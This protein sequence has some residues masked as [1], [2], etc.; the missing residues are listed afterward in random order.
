LKIDE[1]KYIVLKSASE[2]MKKEG[3]ASLKMGLVTYFK[4][5]KVENIY[6]LYGRVRDES[7][8][9]ELN[10]HLKIDFKKKRLEG[11]ECTC[12]EHK[13][14][15]S[16][17]YTFMCAHLTATA[18]KFFSLLS[19][20]E[21]KTA[22]EIEKNTD[23]KAEAAASTGIGRLIRKTEKASV[24][25]EGQEASGSE[26]LILK[27]DEI[28]AF[29]EKIKN[30]K[31]KFKFDYIEFIAQILHEDLPLT[32]NLKEAKE[33]I[34]VTTQKQLPVPL[35]SNNDVFY[36]KSQLYLPSKA[37]IEKYSAIY[38]KLKTKGETYYKKDI[39][40]YNSLLSFLSSISK[41]INIAE[42]LR[43]FMSALSKP[44]FLMY[45]DKG[46]IYCQVFLN[47]GNRKVNILEQDKSTDTLHRDY[48][49]EEKLLMEVERHGL[50][51]L[52]NRFLFT[53]N[54]EE[55]V[56]IL[57]R[58]GQGI[59]SI[60]RV[61]FGKG[62]K[63]IKIYNRDSIEADLYEKEGS[64]DFVYSIGNL[65]P[66]ELKSAFEAYRAKSK[67]YKTRDNGFIDF[68]DDVVRGLFNMFEV[69]NFD[70]E[71][72]DGTVKVEKSKALYVY[73]NLKNMG[74]SFVKG[75][76]AME[77]L[78]KKLTDVNSS[79]IALPQK[80]K[81]TLR[82]YQIK[83]FKWLKTL[84]KLGFGGILAD[85]MGLGKTIQT[86]AFILS[87]ENKRTLIVCPTSLIYNWREEFERFAPSLKVGIL[88]G[89]ERI[90]I[91]KNLD[92][93]DV[94]LTTYSTLRMDIEKYD[95]IL[96]H[97]C[98]IDE[99]Q[100]IKNVS[101]QNTKVIKEI[102]AEVKFALTGTPLENN[103]TELWSIF[104]FV[105]PGY[106][107]SKERFEEKFLAN[108]GENFDNLKLLIKPF[109]LR[110]TK[111][112]VIQELPDKIEK[113]FLVEM[114]TAQ[115]AV[116]SAYIQRVR[117]LLKNNAQGK[118]EVFSYLTKLRQI[119]LDPSLVVEEY[120]GGSG[121][122]KVAMELIK[123]HI[124]ASGKVLLF[125][126][127]TSVLEKIGENLKKESI[128][129]YHL[130]G[131]TKPKDRIQ[132][133]KDFNSSKLVKVF[134]IS[135]KAGGTGLNLTS[136]NLVIHFDPWWNPAVEDQASDRAHRIGQTNVVEVIRLVSKGTIEEK[137][138][139]LQES[140]KE[141]IDKVL[142]GELQGSSAIN[143]LSKEELLKLFNRD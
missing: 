97:Y 131:K 143:S 15:A 62:L 116:Y 104:D 41:N 35:S 13:E 78:E 108:G 91:M 133:V 90:E 34:V 89:A 75:G 73:G 80:L 46:K 122:L 6:H 105:M 99:G 87:E 68:E 137:I 93:Y 11:A 96:F 106:L 109:I 121:K 1:L 67:I 71:I 47:Y 95:N 85:E 141:L 124:E 118:V 12:A 51:Q 126:Q 28:R 58:R 29:L 7:K 134:L 33:R 128:E 56:H 82:E 9:T 72:K 136:A 81:S 4:G 39:N 38:E 8:L 88:H 37:Q 32:F 77:E 27:P 142:T 48:K 65:E 79:D 129:F 102:K 55:L 26:K 50:I 84:S 30:N 86:I 120:E 18:Y 69:L 76:E 53:G 139:L 94:I 42:S 74:L 23:K 5:K 44:E 60:G 21:T 2:V 83:G 25:Y 24:Y 17:G 63:E 119:C 101:A 40:N 123:N 113:K 117:A 125:S 140:K 92:E 43:N 103:L 66:S 132:R 110:R 20:D 111:K 135:L 16:S 130:D 114:T 14:F 98:I 107:Y 45:Q 36:F 127:F 100:N 49:K 10:T 115:K 52:N 54:E 57:S 19:R 59:H 64:Y 22:E 61:I 70:N 138:I 112:E 3:K 31:I